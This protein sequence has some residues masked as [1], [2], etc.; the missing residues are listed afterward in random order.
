MAKEWD[1][2]QADYKKLKPAI[3]KHSTTEASAVFTRF[4]LAS[5]NLSQG[6][7]NLGDST[8]TARKN[9]V[10]GDK[11]TDFMKDKSFSDAKKLLD[12]VVAEYVEQLQAVDAFC[13]AA[14]A[15]SGDVAVLQK[16]IEKD[17]KSRKDK[18]E[19]K[20]DIEALLA[21]T[22][23]DI[24]ELNKSVAYKTKPNPFQRGYA[25]NFAKH[26]DKIVKEAPEEQERKK[27]ATE[28]PQLFV[29]RNIKTNFTKA[30]ALG[31]AVADACDKAMEAAGNDMAAAVP[32]LK[33][34]QTALVALKGLND[35]YVEAVK[36]FQADI[37]NSKDK[38]KV[39]KMIAAIAKSFDTAAR[40][41]KGASTTIKK[42]S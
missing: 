23:D 22:V 15:V 6:E 9:G 5:A 34:A 16:A 42:A 20:K 33:A 3:G 40:A 31:K 41:F 38:D 14:A 28:M 37:D 2:F 32:H 39:E 10:T 36:K 29:D 25:A 7:E 1:K 8:V 26:L 18:S 30:V 17:L 11:L 35:S 19:S 27:N 21:T 12:K 13:D 24:K 4:K